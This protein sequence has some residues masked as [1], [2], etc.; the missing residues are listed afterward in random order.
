MA[1]Y[2]FSAWLL[3]L[4]FAIVLGSWHGGWAMLGLPLAVGVGGPLLLMML[5]RLMRAPW[6][7]RRRPTMADREQLEW[8]S[9]LCQSVSTPSVTVQNAVVHVANQAFLSLLG[10][11]NRS[12]EMVSL[13]FTNLLHPVD[14]TRFISLT[15][16]AA[17][18]HSSGAEGVLRLVSS[19]GGLIKALVSISR[20]PAVPGGL[21]IQLGARPAGGDARQLVEDSL[22]VVFDQLDMVLFQ[23]D[24]KGAIVY[25]NRA[26]EWLSGRTVD[27]SSGLVLC[28]VAH[29]DDR[30]GTEA[31]LLAVG[32]GQ[33]D[34]FESEL[35]IVGADGGI[36]WVVLR[37]HAC[38][39]PDGDLIGIV[40]TL[41]EVTHRKRVELG[42]GSTRR[43][44]NTL[45]ANV[46]GMV[47]RSRNDRDWTMEFVSDGC[48]G[49]TGYEPFELVE[50]H[51]LSYGSLVDPL[52]REFV[53]SQVQ[54]QLAQ[55]QSYQISYRITD[56]GGHQRWVWEQGR[57][58]FSSQGEFLAIEGF[59]TDIGAQT[60]VQQAQR[61]AWFEARTGLVGREL[62]DRLVAHVLQQARLG[63]PCALLWVEIT[64]WPENMG[65]RDTEQAL[66]NLAAR[67]D[68]PL[69]SG[70]T[71]VY[72]G[73]CCF[74]MLLTG[75]G[76]CAP[77]QVP[78]SATGVIGDAALRARQL[79]ACL[80]MPLRIGATEH[81]LPVAC[82]I[83]I[84][85]ARYANAEAMFEAA[86]KAA[87]Q[88]AALGPGHCE[89]ADE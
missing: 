35:R 80:S 41:T 30:A 74:G 14:R 83:A 43:Y 27:G 24:V 3:S 13:P 11:R 34:H 64:S 1:L 44:L 17:S 56:A 46:P 23:T 9:S 84:G 22:S 55:H 33:L 20:L 69:E 76:C 25:V 32:R 58:V 81:R 62:F 63:W 29:P 31:S 19:G 52:D 37:A 53:W 61:E 48:L 16:A 89:V 59:I 39:R 67:F 86:R 72:L 26:W 78:P 40:G 73:R 2:A 28:T 5:L 12:D 66:V 45:L 60:T 50:N 15:A 38:I 57:G 7:P 87:L 4:L 6:R 75:L 71:V 51:R 65:E 68:A 21:L 88:A 85:A 49:L 54:V 47:Y 18:D 10:Y 79:V 70:A 42:L 77:G 82:G 36:V 8:A